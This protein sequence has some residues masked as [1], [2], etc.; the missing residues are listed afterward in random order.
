MGKPELRQRKFLIGGIIIFLALGYLGFM[1]FQSSWTYYYT[2]NELTGQGSAIYD[3]NVRVHGQVAPSS[4]EHEAVGLILRFI[5]TDGEENLL[6]FYQGVIPDSFKVGGDVVVE[7]H[8]NSDGIFQASR[9]MPKCPS[10]YVPQ[11]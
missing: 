4:V 10:K 11:L 6:V 7:G 3:Q 2:V 5:I 1:G 9:V 8:L